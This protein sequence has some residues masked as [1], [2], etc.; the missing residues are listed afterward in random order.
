MVKYTNDFEVGCPHCGE[1]N[2]VV[3][4][5]VVSG[6]VEMTQ[7]CD[8]C[9]RPMLIRIRRDSDD[10]FDVSVLPES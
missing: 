1:I 8:V 3:L 2:A 7:D 10:Q 9:C 5:G 4:E 6:R